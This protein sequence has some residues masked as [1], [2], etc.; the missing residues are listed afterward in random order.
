M[1]PPALPHHHMSDTLRIAAIP[2]DIAW[3]DSAANLAALGAAMQ[4]LPAG[5][6]IA[7]VPE[8]F[9]TGFVHDPAL[10]AQLAQP[11]S[12]STVAALHH[13][14]STT[15]VAIAGS[16]M[17]VTT[18]RYY[19]RGFFIEPSG[20]ET[21]Y[22][23]RHLF[24]VSAESEVFTPG[25]ETIPVVR[26]R[27]WNIAMIVCYDLRF[28]A[29]CRNRDTAYDV[30]LVPA[31]WAT[32]REYA[33]THLLIA[34]AIENQAV[35]VGANRS[36]HDDYGDYDGTTQIYDATGHPC[37]KAADTVYRGAVIA[38]LSADELA[39]ARRRLPVAA[40]ADDFLLKI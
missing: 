34:R 40:D 26:F 19:N 11:N 17:A 31:N 5:T 13:F 25:S 12:G 9:T 33:W 24:C 28:P 21:F 36:G 27:G 16:I 23:K 37:G 6:D 1:T 15:G 29:W 4:R 20:D 8:L 10:A 39:R 35:V 2:I 38:D 7:V 30:L 32:A 22:D 18:G 14:A 3:G